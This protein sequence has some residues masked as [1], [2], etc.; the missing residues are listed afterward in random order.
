MTIEDIEAICDNLPAVTKDIKWGE[1]LCFNV[2]NKIFLITSPD[3]YPPNAVFKVTPEE[4]E[5]IVAR[6]GFRQAPH[7]AKN[8][9]IKIDDIG[10][11]S[12]IQWEYYTGR[13]YSLVVAKLS[14]KKQ[15]ELITAT[16]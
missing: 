5:E 8:L 7:L 13:S 15:A 14:K 3:A 10:K 1:H 11:M 2:A 12:K 9:W 4:F 6:D 16:T